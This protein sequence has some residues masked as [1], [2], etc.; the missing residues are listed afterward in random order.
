[1]KQPEAER[2]GTKYIYKS[3]RSMTVRIGKGGPEIRMDTLNGDLLIHK[4]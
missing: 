4:Q 2:R 1:M 3:N